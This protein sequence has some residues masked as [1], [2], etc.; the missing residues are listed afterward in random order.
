MWPGSTLE[1][2][3]SADISFSDQPLNFFKYKYFIHK[4]WINII[5]FVN[6]ITQN[7][8]SADI[9]FNFPCFEK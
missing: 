7:L 3:N 5:G 8:R 9:Y 2:R 6:F 4:F 1:L